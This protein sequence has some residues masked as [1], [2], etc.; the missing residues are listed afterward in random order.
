MGA[1]N[2]AQTPGF[3]ATPAVGDV[4]GVAGAKIGE[5]EK[6]S[7]DE[8][9]RLREMMRARRRHLSKDYEVR[10]KLGEGNFAL[11]RLCTRK[12]D[13][14]DFAVKIIH[15][16]RM[17]KPKQQ[18][19]LEREIEILM[20]VQHP[21]CVKLE[22]IRETQNH[23]YLVLEYCA[24]G[25]L[26]D[27]ICKESK[28]TE[29]QSVKVIQQITSALQYLH[30]RGIVHRDIKP[31]NI[32]LLER[33]ADSVVKLTDF[34]LANKID[35]DN[36]GLKTSCGTLYYA[37]P[38]VLGPGPYVES[39]DYWSLGVVLY[40]LL[41]GYLP[42]Y[43]DSRDETIN[44]IRRARVHFDMKDWGG[45]SVH[46]RDII[47]KLLT[48]DAKHR[49]NGETILQ[50]EWMTSNIKE[51]DED[52]GVVDNLKRFQDWKNGFTTVIDTV[53]AIQKWKRIAKIQTKTPMIRTASALNGDDDPYI[54]AGEAQDQVYYNT[55]RPG[56][57]Y[58]PG[59]GSVHE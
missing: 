56:V 17:S 44:Q 28:F 31:E 9:K 48:R 54:D 11:V 32:L 53:M 50:H 55:N 57:R 10:K 36:N 6:P 39:I 14:K 35:G 7:E 5:V 30:G 12:S 15:R 8:R 20:T 33:N 47:R 59:V 19:A 38:E 29:R 43:H 1:N 41:V 18:V 4:P 46:A 25:E 2:A 21:N 13:S 58:V 3:V 42:F 45:I 34:G 51:M 40:V 24:G 49:L 52:L 26:F 16:K 37:A 22:D 23:V 27:M